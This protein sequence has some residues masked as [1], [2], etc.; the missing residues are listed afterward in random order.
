MVSCVSVRF[1]W[2]NLRSLAARFL[3][4]APT[5][6]DNDKEFAMS[7]ADEIAH[8]EQHGVAYGAESDEVR[9]VF[10]FETVGID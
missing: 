6:E 10:W 2:H 8:L 3:R 7:K 5:I 1:A 9:T 4:Q